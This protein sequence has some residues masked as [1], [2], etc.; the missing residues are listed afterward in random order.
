MEVVT[1]L[2]PIQLQMLYVPLD[3]KKKPWKMKALIPRN[4]G[5]SIT[6]KKTRF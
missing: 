1:P 4:M 6:P 3:P 5:Y 2:I